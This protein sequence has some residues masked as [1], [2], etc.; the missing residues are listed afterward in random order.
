MNYEI[1]N[2]EEKIVVGV[3][4]RTGNTDPDCQ[5]IIGGLWQDFMGKG[6][7]ASLENKAN[8]YCVG[9]YSDYN[10]D[11]MTYDVTVGAEVSA[12]ENSEFSEKTIPAGKYA[13][14]NVKG[15]VVTDV[16]N[17]WNEIWAMPLE[18]SFTGDFEE[19]LS[20]ENG[21]ADVNI[22]IALK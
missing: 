14:F 2:L 17:A 13:V 16:S 18:R 15:D 20:N 3:T 1:V 21:V 5:K 6:I 19:Y 9:L 8:V 22:Y 10:F 12:N 11:E 7:F 4:A